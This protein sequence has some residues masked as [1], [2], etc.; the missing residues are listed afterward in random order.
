MKK[1]FAFAIS[2]FLALNAL[3]G[4]SLLADDVSTQAVNP[5]CEHKH[6]AA[7]VAPGRFEEWRS[8]CETWIHTYDVYHCADCGKTRIENDVV[9]RVF[10]HNYVETG[11]EQQADGSVLVCYECQKCGDKYSR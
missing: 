1:L 7:E 11:I 2:A 6:W 3:C 8:C 9:T 10:S 4:V 5:P